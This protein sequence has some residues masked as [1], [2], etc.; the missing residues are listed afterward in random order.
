MSLHKINNITVKRPINNQPIF[1]R[2]LLHAISKLQRCRAY[3]IFPVKGGALIRER[4]LFQ[5]WVKL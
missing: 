5:L 2:D 1:S 4:C 3:F